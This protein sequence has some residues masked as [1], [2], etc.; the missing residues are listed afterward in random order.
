MADYESI[1]FSRQD[2]FGVEEDLRSDRFDLEKGESATKIAYHLCGK[3][4]L[5][6]EFVISEEGKEEI[7]REARRIFRMMCEGKK[8]S[9]P[10]TEGRVLTIACVLLTRNSMNDG[11]GEQDHGEIWQPILDGL[12]FSEVSLNTGCSEQ[13]ARRY[14][15]DVLKDRY[16]V[17]F[18]AEGGAK[19]L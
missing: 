17:R 5:I 9:L 11:E 19:I 6:G 15:C 18:F 10:L 3:S 1:I 14:L 2:A 8:D 13:L 7:L 4:A 16:N 12:N